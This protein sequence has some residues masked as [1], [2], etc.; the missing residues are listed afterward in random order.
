MATMLGVTVRGVPEGLRGITNLLYGVAVI[1]VEMVMLCRHQVASAAGA[2][3]DPR[4]VRYSCGTMRQ[5]HIRVAVDRASCHEVQIVL[6][7]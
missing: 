3:Y 6:Y 7:G 5:F 2:T 1:L 4:V